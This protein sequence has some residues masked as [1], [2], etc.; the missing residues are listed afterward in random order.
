MEEESESESEDEEDIQELMKQ[1]KSLQEKADRILEERKQSKRH[2]KKE[3]HH[4]Q[5]E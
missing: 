2:S 3:R 1:I 4:V 5:E